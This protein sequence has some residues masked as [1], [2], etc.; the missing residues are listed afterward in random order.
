MSADFWSTHTIAKTIK[1]PDFMEQ[2]RLATE[3]LADKGCAYVRATRINGSDVDTIW[4]EGWI[5]RPA[6]GAPVFDEA[7]LDPRGKL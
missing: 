1:R 6:D 3:A 5:E 2:N 7:A 4:H